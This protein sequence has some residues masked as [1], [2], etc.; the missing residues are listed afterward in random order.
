[1]ILSVHCGKSPWIPI[2]RNT[3]SST[4]KGNAPIT[5]EVTIS[6]LDFFHVSLNSLNYATSKQIGQINISPAVLNY[7][8]L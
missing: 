5:N 1:M 7:S 3:F 6:F 8:M 2:S 4:T